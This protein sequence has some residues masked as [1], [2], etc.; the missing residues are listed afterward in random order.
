MGRPVTLFTGQWAD[1][2]IEEAAQKVSAWGYDGLEL[3]CWGNQF[4]VNRALGDPGYISSVRAIFDKYNLKLFAISNHLVGQI[5]CD[6]PNPNSDVWAEPAAVREGP[7]AK[8]AWAVEEMKRTMRAA[9]KLGVKVVN[10]FTGSSIWHL[11]YFFPPVPEPTI[12]EGYRYFAQQWGPILDE[13]HRHG[14]RFALEVH[15]TEI[16]YDHYTWRR[17]LEAVDNHPAFYINYDPSHLLWVGVDPVKFIF[18]NGERIAHAHVKEARVRHDGLNA[19]HGSHLQF[20]D[21]RRAWDF[22]SPGRGDVPWKEVFRALYQVGYYGP[23]SVEWEDNGMD[24]DFGAAEAVRFVKATDYV[25][26]RGGS[27]EDAFKR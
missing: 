21:P 14:V 22:V 18:A 19:I 25:P 11:N 27:F 26:N 16:A 10:G 13:A 2:T 6:P 9:A 20:G 15:P 17:A 8:R 5:V 4:D 1:L 24:R 3:C 23:L 12:E 7:E